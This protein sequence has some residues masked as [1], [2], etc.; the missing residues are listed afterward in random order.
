M[1]Y[2]NLPAKIEGKRERR[3]RETAKKLSKLFL[4]WNYLRPSFVP[5]ISNPFLVIFTRRDETARFVDPRKIA[6]GWKSGTNGR[7]GWR[8]ASRVEYLWVVTYARKPRSTTCSNYARYRI[9]HPLPPPLEDENLN[10]SRLRGPENFW[11]IFERR[12]A[13]LGRFVY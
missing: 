8:I 4:L 12:K 2:W 7:Q 10:G 6:E 9:G 5:L 3:E 13:R 11:E 1:R